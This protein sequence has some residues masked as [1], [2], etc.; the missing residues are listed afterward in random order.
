LNLAIPQAGQYKI[1]MD[2]EDGATIYRSN[3][4]VT[5]FPYQLKD[6][7]GNPIVTIRGS[8]F[9]NSATNA[10]DT[11]TAAWYYLYNLRVRSLACP[12][13]TRTAVTV[14]PSTIVTAAIRADGSTNVCRGGAVTLQASVPTSAS[15]LMLSYRWQQN[16][17]AI[18]GATNTSLLVSLGGSYAVQVTGS[19]APT[20]SSAVVVSVRD[21]QTPTVT[22]TDL[23][24]ASNAASGNQW[25][26]NGIP[27]PGAT[28]SSFVVGQTGKYSVQANVNGCGTAISAEVLVTILATEDE[29]D[30][31]FL[32]VYPNPTQDLVTVEVALTSTNPQ[33]PT[34]SLT[35][36]RGIVLRTAPMQRDGKKFT[37]IL[38][39]ADLP[40][41]TFFVVISAT[42][43]ENTRR[44]R[45]I[46]P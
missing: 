13:A 17:Q 25:L 34:I 14:V 10:I 15:G 41:G 26:L 16:G 18:S 9:A 24:L 27:I 7:S 46:K 43:A 6:Q 44:R 31:N 45:L 29:P 4:G 5:G 3:V 35:D 38:S 1:V 12:V 19:C 22:Q 11:L 23:V 30:N 39:V 20:T 21:P 33:P 2:Y 8:L 28:S 37:A 42:D 36:L 32:V 40:G